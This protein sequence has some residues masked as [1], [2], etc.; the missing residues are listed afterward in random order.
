MAP[1]IYRAA[2]K[3]LLVLTMLA[4]P[5]VTFG[6]QI[7]PPK[8]PHEKY[9][10][11]NGLT[12]ILH[13]DHATP[14]VAVN[15]WYHVGSK[16]ERRGRT[17]FAHLFE[18]M[19]FQGSTHHDTDYFQ[20]LESVGATDL[21]GSTDND[22][23]NY[24]QNVPS[25]ALERTLW[26]EADRMC[27][28]LPAMTKERLDN[29]REVVKNE[30]RQRVDNQPYGLVEE[31]MDA[32]MYP[33]HHPYS[34]PVI[35]Y[36]EDLTAASKE[37]V[38]NFFK[39]YYTP[40][41][42]TLVIVGDINIPKT[43]AMVEKYFGPIPPGPP[44]GR[45]REWVPELQREVR[46]S[47]DDQAPM[48]RLYIAW[49]SPARFT[50]GEANLDLLSSIMG[51]GKSSRLYKRLVY[52]LKLAQD[53]SVDSLAQEIAGKFTITVTAAPGKTLDEIEPLVWEEV[54]KVRAAA[55][56]EEEVE[57]VRTS[58]L[59]GM[60][61]GLEHIGGFDGKSDLLAN[62]QTYLGDPNFLEKDFA[63]YYAVTPATIHAAARRW[64]HEGRAVMRVTPMPNYAAGKEASGFD[65]AKTPPLGDAV[66]LALPALQ[67]VKLSNGLE[68]VL[69]ESHKTPTVQLNLIVRGGWSA[70]PKTKL[71]LSSF[72]AA[73][74]T[75]GTATRSALQISDETERLGAE[76]SSG[77]FLDSVTVSLNALKS[78][79]E[80][81]ITLW[82]DV[83]LNPSFPQAEVERKREQTLGRIF[84]EKGVP[85]A[86]AA[87]V[88]PMLLY[89]DD[90]PYAQPLTGS[91]TPESV[92]AF[93]RDDLANY[94]RA[95]F[96][97]NNAVLV[98]TGDTTL[99][100]ITPL[101]EKVFA[102]WKPGNTPKII[103]PSR[104]QPKQTVIYLIDKPGAAQSV[105]I[106][107][108]L[109]APRSDPDSTPFE[110]LNALLG[111][112]FTSRINMN[113]REEKGYTYGAG[114]FPFLAKGQG[115]LL[116]FAPVRTDVTKESLQELMKELRE[117][118]GAR[119]V[120]MDEVKFAQS[121]LTMSLPGQYE[122]AS[123]IAQKISDIVT[124][125]LP[126]NFYSKYPAVVNSTTPEG[127]TALAKKL[128][129]PEQMAL[130]IVGDRAVIEPKIKE[131]NLGQINY[132]DADGKPT[133]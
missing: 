31:R 39:E 56:T 104:E 33:P 54:E 16:N 91:G 103:I 80:P 19:M 28:L 115:V 90:H 79:L 13:E 93:M 129:L 53:V 101:L 110:V 71:G 38:E 3:L 27:C 117:I 109:L 107:G 64:L 67:R 58:L 43:K 2:P 87:R 36:M 108:H 128:L 123:G 89:G 14:I 25:H 72:T 1:S 88:L 116:L 44:L 48:P 86:L 29:Q 35:G 17:G 98:V 60:L 55:P 132:I 11:S 47:M 131:L 32:A 66:A 95:W 113:L 23:T 34:W 4:V 65:R 119:P 85:E 15:L 99:K 7:A 52:D 37:D 18:H 96:K 59:A 83:I 41:N 57:R 114:T 124:Y 62:Y 97:P 76:L 92:K 133:K 61:R 125:N 75:E 74:Q 26:V 69:A 126:D 12:V 100:E 106:G 81:S 73:L 70:D 22:R 111:G 45:G 21:N 102:E 84:S 82:A 120:T 130:L 68:I 118:R 122:T 24:F 46:L 77:S 50:A 8:I 9:T 20:A 40:N 105:I 94:H 42:C 10:L 121:N 63:R 6:Q 49:H 112:Q 127:L 5:A 78:R 51:Q 30:R